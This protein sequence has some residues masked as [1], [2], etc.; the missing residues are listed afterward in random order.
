MKLYLFPVLDVLVDLVRPWHHEIPEEDGLGG[1]HLV[2]AAVELTDA[3]LQQLVEPLPVLGAHQ[4]VLEDAAALVVPQ[5]QQVLLR[6]PHQASTIGA[7][8]V[9]RI[10]RNKK[11]NGGYCEIVFFFPEHS[12]LRNTETE[13]CYSRKLLFQKV[14]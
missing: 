11:L 6:L 10:L 14:C 8:L 1:H 5:P 7:E 12:I 13:W 3:A 2:E 4:P 9:Q